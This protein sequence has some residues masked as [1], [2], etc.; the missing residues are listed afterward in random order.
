MSRARIAAALMAAST[1]LTAPSAAAHQLDVRKAGHAV[2][3]RLATRY[4]MGAELCRTE[5]L[6]RYASHRGSR[7]SAR[8]GETLC[9]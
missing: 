6:V 7:P 1:L 5:V 3:C 4:Q 8:A 9:Y 2:S